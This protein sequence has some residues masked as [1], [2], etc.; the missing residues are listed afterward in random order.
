[1][2]T[3]SD[4]WERQNRPMQC[5]LNEG[6][7]SAWCQSTDTCHYHHN[8]CTLHH[9]CDKGYCEWERVYMCGGGKCTR[10]CTELDKTL[11]YNGS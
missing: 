11:Q 1:M 10:D 6:N 2:V 3:N 9:H 4:E 7:D 8:P 5:I